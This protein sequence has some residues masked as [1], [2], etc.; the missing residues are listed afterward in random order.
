MQRE[1]GDMK[2]TPQTTVIFTVTI[3]LDEVEARALEAIAGYGV[4]SFLE[5]FYK[6]GSHYLKPHEAGVRSLFKVI[7]EDINPQLY[8]VDGLR[9]AIKQAIERP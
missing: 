4:D 9:E 5:V 3:E 1:R 8:R 7:K 2:N 6:L